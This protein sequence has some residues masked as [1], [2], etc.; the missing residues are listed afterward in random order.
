[1]KYVKNMNPVRRELMVL[2][3]TMHNAEMEGMCDG[4]AECQKR[5][6][7][8]RAGHP[9]VAEAYFREL[10]AADKRRCPRALAAIELM[11]SELK[12]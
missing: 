12:A 8:I 7:E 1:M 6:N 5:I 2:M 10:V 4:V 9:D 11:Q 3:A